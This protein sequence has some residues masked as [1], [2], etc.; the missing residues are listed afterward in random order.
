MPAELGDIQYAESRFE[1]VVNLDS[2]SVKSILFASLNP[3]FHIR[4]YGGLLTEC[5]SGFTMNGFGKS[6]IP[7]Y[8]S[9]GWDRDG[10]SALSFASDV[11][12]SEL[13]I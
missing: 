10:C 9:F 6:N 1:I 5:E 13:Y 7:L 3:D 8:V 2:Y 11:G 4:R 12:N